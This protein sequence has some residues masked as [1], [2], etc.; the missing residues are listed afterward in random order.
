MKIKAFA[1]MALLVACI[2]NALSS[3]TAG[4]CSNKDEI[5]KELSRL[6][7]DPNIT[8]NSQLL[9]GLELLYG[10]WL[11]YSL[12]QDH[13]ELENSPN[14]RFDLET[15]KWLERS[16][17]N[18]DHNR[19]RFEFFF[20][21]N[22]T[23][24]EMK[25][26]AFFLFDLLWQQGTKVTP[27]FANH[28]DA[29]TFNAYF[30][31]NLKYLAPLY[32]ENLSNKELIELKKNVRRFYIDNKNFLVGLNNIKVSFPVISITGHGLPNNENIFIGGQTYTAE[33]IAEILVQAGLQKEGRIEIRACFSGCARRRLNF[34]VKQIKTL[35]MEGHLPALT[36]T[37]GNNLLS[38]FSEALHD[39]APDFKGVVFGYLGQL[40]YPE[41]DNVFNR[42]GT[43]SPT[44]FAVVLNGLDGEIFVNRDE[45]T[46]AINIG[47]IE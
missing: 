41:S 34:T 27:V 9:D 5:K 26:F 3:P 19:T 14:K 17:W 30:T 16:I 21:Q 24:E 6:S 2:P 43:T 1:F 42:D 35:F 11:V 23:E 40:E 15:I 37:G 38:W 12:T 8:T 47:S 33:Q 45:A 46:V 7:I 31:S 28:I 29:A 13:P 44:G 36:M 32:N 22:P 20:A 39:K 4:A 18:T 25:M 10:G